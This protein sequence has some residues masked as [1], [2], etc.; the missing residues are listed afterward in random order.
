MYNG[1]SRCFL[2]FFCLPWDASGVVVV[3]TGVAVGGELEVERDALGTEDFS[4]CLRF[5]DLSWG[6]VRDRTD[7]RGRDVVLSMPV[8]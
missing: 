3:K 2:G 6:F 1:R 7:V 5:F 4:L 8:K